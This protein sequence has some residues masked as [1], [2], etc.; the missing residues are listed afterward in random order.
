[1]KN[2]KILTTSSEVKENK[3]KKILEL[4]SIHIRKKEN[5]V[6][7]NRYVHNHPCIPQMH[8][9]TASVQTNSVV[10]SVCIYLI[11]FQVESNNF[12]LFCFFCVFLNPAHLMFSFI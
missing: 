12:N 1:M 4:I 5:F 8:F 9:I 10:I 7:Y 2:I 3:K 6:V 11:N